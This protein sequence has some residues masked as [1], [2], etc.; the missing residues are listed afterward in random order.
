MG[1]SFAVLCREMQNCPKG[2]QQWLRMGGKQQGGLMHLGVLP[3]YLR[4]PPV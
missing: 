2:I 3:L 1:S 4:L